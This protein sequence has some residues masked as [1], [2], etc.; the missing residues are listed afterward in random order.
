MKTG[1]KHS[2]EAKKR[3]RLAQLGRK[4]PQE[5]KDKIRRAHLGRK[6]GKKQRERI[7]LSKL[8]N[9]YRLGKKASQS[10]IEKM[11]KANLG[12]KLSDLTRRKMSE[13]H[14]GLHLKFSDE[15]KKKISDALRGKP[16]SESARSKQRGELHHNWKGGITS[17]NRLIRE[18]PES[19]EW[20]NKVFI[21]DNYTCKICGTKGGQLEVD[22]IDRF[23]NIIKRN[24]I[25]T[26]EEAIRCAE[27]WSVLNGRT[28]CKK[29]HK[30]KTKDEKDLKKA[31]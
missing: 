13:S 15:H 25:T 12:K 1:S 11:R 9:K 19:Y 7:R 20:K 10:T 5:V 28:L 17:L 8:G 23:C 16:K 27:L 6:F 18:L 14:L 26:V 21:R 2:I 22:H 31:D 30:R 4:H 3:M 29:C 24:K